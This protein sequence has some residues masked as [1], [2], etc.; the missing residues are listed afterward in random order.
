MFKQVAAGAVIPKEKRKDESDSEDK[1]IQPNFSR[2]KGVHYHTT[3]TKANPIVIDSE[4]DVLKMET[5]CPELIELSDNKDDNED[6]H[7]VSK[8]P[9]PAQ[10]HVPAAHGAIIT[11]LPELSHPHGM[12]WK[13]KCNGKRKGLVQSQHQC[14]NWYHLFLW[15]DINCI[16]PK[17]AWSLTLIAQT[18][19]CDKPNL[20]GTLRKGT[21]QKWILKSG[22]RWSITTLKNV[23]R[24]HALARSGCVGILA[25][26]PDIVAEIK[27]NLTDLHAASITVG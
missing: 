23:E 14:T 19:Q 17:V 1:D 18:L 9:K 22:R 26:Y 21:V 8:L 24:R 25:L 10:L 3:A 13:A 27:K 4:G 16:A 12:Q 11:N 20:Y 7:N 2:R 5:N 15:A 6:W